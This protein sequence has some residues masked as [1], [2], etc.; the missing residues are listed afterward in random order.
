MTLLLKP[1]GPDP[2]EPLIQ[3]VDLLHADNFAGIN[4][5]LSLRDVLELSGADLKKHGTVTI[6]SGTANRPEGEEKLIF[7]ETDQLIIALRITLRDKIHRVY[8]DT[9]PKNAK[10]PSYGYSLTGNNAD[11][12]ARVPF[13]KL[14]RNF[15]QLVYATGETLKAALLPITTGKIPGFYSLPAQF[16]DAKRLI[17]TSASRPN[18]RSKKH[19]EL[20]LTPRRVRIETQGPLITLSDAAKETSPFSELDV[21]SMVAATHKAYNNLE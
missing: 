4:P 20:P 5:H 9:I 17:L 13:A 7:V 19:P 2:S 10:V 12:K 6:T 1:Q 18:P 15:E 8:I 16:D 21:L 11:N 14:P 3:T